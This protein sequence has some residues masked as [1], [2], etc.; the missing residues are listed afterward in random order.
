VKLSRRHH[1]LT[2]SGGLPM[3][4]MIDVVFLL[5]IFFMVTV[6]ASPPESDL[7]STLKPESKTEG[8]AADFQPQIV[9]VSRAGDAV[10]Y[11]LG[12]HQLTT[13]SDLARLLR[14]LPK[15]SGVVVKVRNDVPVEAAAGALQTCK[16]VGFTKVSYVPAS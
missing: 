10:V 11:T 5:L 13:R 6:S 7:A 15:N 8:A 16:D 3:T 1:D 12:S 9:T 2:D 4:S 14:E